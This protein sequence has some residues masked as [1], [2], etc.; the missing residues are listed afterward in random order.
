M[1]ASGWHRIHRFHHS[2]CA[3][4]KSNYVPYVSWS[5]LCAAWK[6]T[7][8]VQNGQLNRQDPPPV[9]VVSELVLIWPNSLCFIYCLCQISCIF[10]HSCVFRNI[11][12]GALLALQML[13]KHYQS[14]QGQTSYGNWSLPDLLLCV[15][16]TVGSLLASVS[17]LVNFRVNICSLEPLGDFLALKPCLWK[18]HASIHV[19]YIVY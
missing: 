7:C 6:M 19:S 9:F 8:M 17:E 12:A 10:L 14:T 18:A 1:T 4:L 11:K 15:T 16:T 5:D 2:C 3:Q 13:I